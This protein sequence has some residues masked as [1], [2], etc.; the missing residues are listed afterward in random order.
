MKFPPD[1][2]GDP[3][4]DEVYELVAKLIVEAGLGDADVFK[5]MK[6]LEESW[7]RA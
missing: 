4:P 1:Q 7:P 5:V 2:W 3:V 6:A